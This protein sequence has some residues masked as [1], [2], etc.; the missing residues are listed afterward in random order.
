MARP[1][2]HD[3][4]IY[5]RKDGKVLWMVYRDRGGKRIRE[6]TF[7]EDWQEAQKKLRERLQSRD[8]RIL[9]VVRKGEQLQFSDWADFFLENYSK[10]PIR[11]EKTH[12]ANERGCLHLKQ[13]FGKRAVGDITVDDIELYLRKRLQTRV[14]VRTAGGVIEKDRLKPAT[15]HQELRILR[16]MMNV[17]VRKKLLPANPCAGVE[18]PVKVKGLFRPHY[19]AWSE[20]Q[21][22]EFQ[23]PEYLRNIIRIISETGLRVYKELMPMKKEQVDLQNAV[24]W[25]PDSKTPNGIAEVPLTDLARDAFQEQIRIAGPGTWLFPSDANPTGHQKTLKTVWHAALRRAKVPYFRIYDLRST[26]ATRLSAGGVADEWVTQLLRQGDAKVFKKYSQMK[27]Q[28]KREALQKLNR[29]ANEDGPGFDTVR[30][31]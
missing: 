15:V 17:A 27:L 1:S 2:K 11:A 7:T 22:I 18:F 25:I 21:R 30:P 10:P 5:P 29:K 31:N 13:A 20:Q 3:G 6:S 16:R 23:A 19:M 12:E 26:Y 9:D 24:V 28:M 4:S 14:Q 8:D